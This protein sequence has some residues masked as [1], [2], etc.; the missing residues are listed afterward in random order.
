V[1]RKKHRD[2]T[3][4]TFT[5]TYHRWK[6]WKY[7]L[8]GAGYVISNATSTGFGSPCVR[9]AERVMFAG[10]RGT[11]VQKRCSRNWLMTFKIQ[12]GTCDGL[13]NYFGILAQL[14]HVFVSMIRCYLHRAG[15][16]CTLAR[17][18]GTLLIRSRSVL[19][20]VLHISP[21]GIYLMDM[22]GGMLPCVSR[23]RRQQCHS[24]PAGELA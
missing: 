11:H 5:T 8:R 10:F 14:S 20:L 22:S 19:S 24:T 17:W 7:V 15:Y 4:K 3:S 23:R 16:G 2:W 12:T 9:P 21:C 1:A 18:M 6:P 13:Y